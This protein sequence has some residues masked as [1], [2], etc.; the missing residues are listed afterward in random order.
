MVLIFGANGMSESILVAT[1]LAAF[2]W[3]IRWW[4][5]DRNMFLIISAMLFGLLPM[6]RYESVVL[7][8][9]VAFIILIQTW[10]QTVNLNQN[11]LRDI[12]EGRLLVYGS[13]VIYPVFLWMVFNWQIMDNPIYFLTSPYSSPSHRSLDTA[14][15]GL[16]FSLGLEFRTYFSIFLLGLIA[17]IISLT[18]GIYHRSYFVITMGL[19][20]LLNPTFRGFYEWYRGKNETLVRYHII[21]IPL[22]LLAIIACWYLFKTTHQ[23]Q[24]NNKKYLTPGVMGALVTIFIGANLLTGYTLSTTNYYSIERPSWLGI[25]IFKP[26]PESE[27][28]T[29]RESFSVGR[30]LPDIIPEGSR[31]L[32]DTYATG[33]AIILSS[34]NPKMFF[35]HTD[36][37]WQEALIRPWEYVDYVLI[38]TSDRS[39][40]RRAYLSEFNR[41]QPDLH[42]KGAPWAEPVDGLPITPYYEWR[43]YKV[44]N[45]YYDH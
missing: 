16:L 44:V 37:N 14:S 42:S 3:L 31:V 10:S 45:H 23:T 12:L 7:V 33:Y 19:L 35:T 28:G 34:E 43:L 21:G 11:E 22:G 38:A 41:A 13:L 24:Q 4:Q 15:F 30:I 29:D 32:L 6:I 9:A 40:D 2:Y 17:P 20:P 36:P 26:I 8:V 1:T 27:K 18:L 5:S 25:N 39:Q